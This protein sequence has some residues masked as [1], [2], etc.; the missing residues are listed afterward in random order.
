[1]ILS[2]TLTI[3]T[4]SLQY[5]QELVHLRFELAPRCSR[6]VN[7]ISLTNLIG[8]LQIAFVPQ[9]AFIFG[10]SVRDNIL[11]GMPYDEARYKAAVKASALEPDLAHLPGDPLHQQIYVHCELL[12]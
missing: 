5:Q 1:M 8:W 2:T 10:A 9:T 12:Q 7:C 6:V 3:T 4:L 11:F